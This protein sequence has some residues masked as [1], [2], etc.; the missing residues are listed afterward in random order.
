MERS[1]Q[2]PRIPDLNDFETRGGL[3]ESARR[4]YE[5]LLDER[6][7]LQDLFSQAST[8]LSFLYNEIPFSGAPATTVI[9]VPG[10]VPGFRA[11]ATFDQDLQ[12]VAL[13]A[14]VSAP[15]TVTVLMGGA[16][17]TLAAGKL[18]VWVYPKV[19]T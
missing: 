17:P 9:T 14:Y 4:M 2:L 7:K 11:E 12:G 15:D 1:P 8:D 6:R 5:Y 3:R 16:A 10:A 13:S 19:L 18:R